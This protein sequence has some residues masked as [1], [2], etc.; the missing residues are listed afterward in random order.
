MGGMRV[1]VLLALAVLCGC[2]A[3]LGLGDYQDAEPSTGSGPVSTISSG[4]AGASSGPGAGGRGGAGGVV[5]PGG[6]GGVAGNAAGS[7]S[8]T[9]NSSSSAGG[10]GAGGCAEPSPVKRVFVTSAAFQGNLG[11][12]AQADVICQEAADAACLGGSW[13]AWLSD[14]LVSAQQHLG[15]ANGPWYLVDGMTLVAQ[16]KQTLLNSTLSHA[17]DKD[18]T[19]TVIAAAVWTGTYQNGAPTGFDCTSWTTNNAGPNGTIGQSNFASQQWTNQVGSSCDQLAHLYCF[20][21]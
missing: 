1:A 4:G 14:N 16:S 2:D 18:P 12:V 8:S 5:D 3:L 9:T 17:I 11:G 10:G 7:T 19:L 21:Q 13:L 6:S 15:N 20:E